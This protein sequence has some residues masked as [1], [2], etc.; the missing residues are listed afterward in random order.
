MKKIMKRAWEIYRTLTGAHREKMSIALKM[1]W[2]EVATTSNE[3][4][5]LEGTEKQVA[6]AERIRY[7]VFGK[8]TS[9]LNPEMAAM[10]YNIVNKKTS[11]KWWIEN[12]YNVVNFE[13]AMKKCMAD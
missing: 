12:M 9:K 8:H 4:V 13:V 6:Y 10:F 7:E 11:A 5:K 1:A 3:F 2:A